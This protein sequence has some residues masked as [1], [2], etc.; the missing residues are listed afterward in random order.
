MSFRSH[1]TVSCLHVH[2]RL[3]SRPSSSFLHFLILRRRH[4][5]DDLR[6]TQ[7]QTDI[8]CKSARREDSVGM[9]RTLSEIDTLAPVSEQELTEL[10]GAPHRW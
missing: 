4:K 8:R 3:Y 2:L 10:R 7:Q 6:R 9:V 1:A 5:H